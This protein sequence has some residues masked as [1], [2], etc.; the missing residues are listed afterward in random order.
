MVARGSGAKN[1]EEN[2]E[3]ESEEVL[4]LPLLY[5]DLVPWYRLVD[6]YEDHEAEATSYKKGFER[7]GMPADATLLDLGAG[8]GGNAY[9]LVDR[10]RCTLADLSP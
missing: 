2:E 1:S 6:P 8:A 4:M 9:F 10:F 3:E 7:D 5:R